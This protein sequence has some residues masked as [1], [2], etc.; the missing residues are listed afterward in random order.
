MSSDDVLALYLARM[1]E[2]RG[3]TDLFCP[4]CGHEAWDVGELGQVGVYRGPNAPVLQPSAVYPLIVVSCRTCGH[5]LMFNAL[6]LGFGAEA[7][8]GHDG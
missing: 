1:E 4:V 7:P 8:N 6:T 5:V 3:T 2:I